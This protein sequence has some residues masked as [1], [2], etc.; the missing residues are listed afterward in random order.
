MGIGEKML[1][2]RRRAGFQPGMP[3]PLMRSHTSWI[4]D[5]LPTTMRPARIL[6][7]HEPFEK[8]A[9]LKIIRKK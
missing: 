4:S 7:R 6:I 2:A 3:S 1:S 5:A 8:S 9:S